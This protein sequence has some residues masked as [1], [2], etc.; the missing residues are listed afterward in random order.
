MKYLKTLRNWKQ[1][2]FIIICWLQSWSSSA[3]KIC[4]CNRTLTCEMNRT[5]K[6]LK[7]IVTYTMSIFIHLKI[8]YINV[9]FF[10]VVALKWWCLKMKY[11][12][13]ANGISKCHIEAQWWWALF[14]SCNWNWIFFCCH[15]QFVHIKLM[16]RP[17]VYTIE[18]ILTKLVA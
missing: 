5:A 16:D 9:W 13:L 18:S 14:L 10:C 6:L 2:V 12:T 7:Q 17:H 3:N 1:F 4:K 8:H 11:I 15:R